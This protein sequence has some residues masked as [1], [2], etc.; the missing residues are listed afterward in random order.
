VTWSVI[1]SVVWLAGI[2]GVRA[3][4][5]TP[6]E[7]NV[8]HLN[9]V[10]SARDVDATIE[11][12][13]DALGL[14]QLATWKMP[15]GSTMLRFL[16]G[17]SELKF[18]VSGQEL[19][20]FEGGAADAL[21]IRL[22]A[23]LLPVSQ[24]SGIEKRFAAHGYDAVSYTQR[25]TYAFG[26]ARDPDGNQVEIV[27]VD[28]SASA[29]TFKQAQIG[30]TVSD[31][32]AMNEFLA[33]VIGLSKVSAEKSP[34]SGAVIHRYAMGVSQ[35]KFWQGREGL[36]AHVG[37]PSEIIGMSLLQ[38][39]VP[40][41]DAVRQAVVSRGGSIHTEP[42]ALGTSSTIMFVDGPDGILFEFAGPMLA[43]LAP[44]AD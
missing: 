17:E 21:G 2:D 16:A 29:A 36:P 22:L 25:P 42:F 24:R 32:A 33:D 13:G 10:V 12:Y 6:F 8:D 30:L 40:D 4:D 19:R 27:F 15:S 37:G 26:M 31:A 7:M 11:F 38:F 28:D 43:R 35:I 9:L 1:V 34:S 14:E 18:I 20:T 3:A 23:L 39:L 5:S 44:S 41:V